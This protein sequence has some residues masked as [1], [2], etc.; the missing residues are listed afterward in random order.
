MKI[1]Q[2]VERL[3]QYP[4]DMEIMIKD[5]GFVLDLNVGPYDYTITEA[6]EDDCGDCDGRVG[7]TVVLIGGGNY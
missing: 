7:E 1:A 3:Q 2:L 4:Q 6:D 5:G